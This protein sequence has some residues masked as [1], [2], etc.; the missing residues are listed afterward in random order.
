[1]WP[2]FRSASFYTAVSVLSFECTMQKTLPILLLGACLALD[3]Q[4]QSFGDFLKS[5]VTETARN[6]ITNSATKAL[7]PNVE[8]PKAPAAA[9]ADTDADTAAAPAAASPAAASTAA[10]SPAAAPK[11]ALA[12]VPAGC[13]RIKGPTL[14]LGP[15]P[16][17][18]EPAIL[19][20]ENTQCPV[21]YFDQ[22]EFKQA[23]AAKRA[24]SDAS[25]FPCSDCEGGKDFD[26]LG[27]RSVVKGDDYMK[28]FPKLLLA[29]ER[30]KSLGWKGKKYSV[31]V[32]AVS[33]HPIGETP[34]KQFHYTLKQGA[35]TVSEYDGMY[36]KW[37]YDATSEAK[38]VQAV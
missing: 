5:A 37:S 2:D 27:W 11:P 7:T 1:M 29:L 15:K 34:C 19:W 22:F 21:R 3:A 26:S 9:D 12:A 4:A 24:F 30:G 17:S 6:V 23:Q 32:T 16:D 35:R 8:Q 33:E 10:A 25:A 38:W 14:T 18:F 20:P 13:K 28:E 31:T 36:C